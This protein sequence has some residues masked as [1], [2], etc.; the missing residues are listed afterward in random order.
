MERARELVKV[1]LQRSILVPLLFLGVRPPTWLV[2]LCRANV[3]ISPGASVRPG[4][5]LRNPRL[6]VEAGARIG[7]LVV[8]D[9][10][11]PITVKAGARVSN[12]AHLSSLVGLIGPDEAA[13]ELHRAVTIAGEEIR[14]R[15]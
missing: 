15:D 4:L 5:V 3:R 13:V 1:G 11:L 7:W 8:I 6:I 2:R 12:F 14:E 10:E 9:G